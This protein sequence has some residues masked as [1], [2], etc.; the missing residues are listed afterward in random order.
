MGV[1][2]GYDRAD[3]GSRRPTNHLIWRAMVT[4]KRVVVWLLERFLEAC[5]LGGLFM[6]LIVRSGGDV[7]RGNLT[8]LCSDVWISGVVVAVLLFVHGYY[9]TTA[10]CGVLWR[11]PKLWVYPAI[12]VAL[13]ALHTH[14]IFLRGKPDLTQEARAMELPFVGGG[15]VVAFMCSLVGNVA[16]KRWTSVRQN[17]GPYLSATGLTLLFFLLLNTANYLR[18][19]IGDSSFRP[20]GLPFTFYREGGY[21]R[22]WVWRNGVLVWRG[23]IADIAVLAAVVMLVGYV[24]QRIRI[25]QRVRQ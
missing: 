24:S 22:E 2:M 8:S 17:S 14:I 23:L 18:P 19:V 9:L 13:F 16:L 3:V 25:A 5:I 7:P 6:Y 21:V 12:T 11:S 20:Y 4:L 1:T 15:A 10:I